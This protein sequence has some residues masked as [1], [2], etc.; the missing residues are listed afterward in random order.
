MVLNTIGA[1]IGTLVLLQVTATLVRPFD[2]NAL[3]TLLA[4]HAVAATFAGVLLFRSVIG[5]YTSAIVMAL[6]ILIRVFAYVWFYYYRKRLLAGKYGAEAKWA[7]ELVDED[8]KAFVEASKNFSDTEIREIGIM[9]H[10][11]AELRKK[12]IERAEENEN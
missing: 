8:D 11:K 3:F 2:T 7:A 6:P 1:I 4:Q 10:S 12:T 9:S 5:L